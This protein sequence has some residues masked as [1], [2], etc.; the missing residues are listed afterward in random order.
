MIDLNVQIARSE[1]Y[2]PIHIFQD[3]I[4]NL[5]AKILM[6]MQGRRFLVVISD[7][8]EKLY[9]KILRFNNAEKIVLKDGEKEKSFANYK[10]ILDK[11]LKMK[12]TRK[13]AIIAIGGGVVGDIAGFAASTYMRGI[14]YIQVPTT[15]LACV[16]SSVGGKVAINTK[17]GKN[18]IGCFYQPK[19]VYI[20]LNFL[21][22]LDER[23]YKSGL[24]EVVKYI[25]I[26]K[27][28]N[29]RDEFNLLN[30][31]NENSESIISRNLNI[32][33]KLIYICLRLKVSVVEQDEKETGLRKI[34]N[35]GH[36]YGHAVESITKYKKYTHGEAVVKGIKFAFSL[37]EQ[38]G[39]VD[40]NYAYMA[41]DILDKFGFK[42]VAA[43]PQEKIINTMKLDKKA[44]TG[45][46]NFILPT[47][48]GVVKEIALNDKEIFI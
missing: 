16:D 14:D 1:N 29:C 45:L 27:S 12:L 22:T 40:K 30:F 4:E 24:G 2:Y 17:D 5:K 46:I 42:N 31:I 6:N 25:F 15:L 39:L 38:K 43:L 21:Q 9:G 23:Q 32:L 28:C 47:D 34:L 3:S 20:N 19:A 37:A 8:V 33:E 10:K 41:N 44:D 18:L 13:D 48:Y 36:T 7:K 26:E 11:A 35:F